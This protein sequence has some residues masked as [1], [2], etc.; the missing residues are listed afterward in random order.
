MHI[1]VYDTMVMKELLGIDPIILS[2]LILPDK[3]KGQNSFGRCVSCSTN[4]KAPD[5]N[6]GMGNKSGRLSCVQLGTSL[7]GKPVIES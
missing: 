4:P 6:G 7:Q 5:D 1:I 2:T 3:E